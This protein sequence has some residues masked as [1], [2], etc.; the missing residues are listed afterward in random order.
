MEKSEFIVFGC[1]D[2]CNEVHKQGKVMIFELVYLAELIIFLSK[3][4]G[5]K[6]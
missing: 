6:Q 3:R 4:A 2:V 1:M 5:G